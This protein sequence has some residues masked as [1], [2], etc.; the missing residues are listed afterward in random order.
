MCKISDLPTVEKESESSE[1]Q[2][3]QKVM[4]QDVTQE[5]NARKAR[6]EAEAAAN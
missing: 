4:I 6:A 3:P 1:V 5:W 2:R